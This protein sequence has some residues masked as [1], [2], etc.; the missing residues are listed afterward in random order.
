VVTLRVW[1]KD[2]E[3]GLSNS[4]EETEAFVQASAAHMRRQILALLVVHG[5]CVSGGIVLLLK[6]S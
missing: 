5:I 4:L 1:L 3:P 2:A 6:L